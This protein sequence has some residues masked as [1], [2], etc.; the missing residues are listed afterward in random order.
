M[1]DETLNTLKNWLFTC[2]GGMDD[3]LSY[4]VT[5]ESVF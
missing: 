5:L 1:T 3:N 2:A 4:G